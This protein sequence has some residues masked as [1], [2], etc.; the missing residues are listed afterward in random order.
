MMRDRE[1]VRDGD[2]EK[3]DSALAGAR[4][5]IGRRRSNQRR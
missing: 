5:G 4:P 2:A 3:S 1:P